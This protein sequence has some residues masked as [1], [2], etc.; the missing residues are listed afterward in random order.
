MH[1]I[2]PAYN[3]VR[4]I[5]KNKNLAKLGDAFINFAYSLAQSFLRNKPYGCKV[6]GKILADAFR[7]SALKMY[8]P[9]RSDTHTLGDFAEAIIAYVWLS[10]LLTLE[11]ITGIIKAGLS[12]FEM[13]TRRDEIE[14]A[15]Y[16]FRLLLDKISSFIIEGKI[17]AKERSTFS[18]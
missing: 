4:K 8:I 6:P 9:S 3:D 14:A 11:D 13:K 18:H 16:A 15:S 1:N 2:L 7:R 17:I 5:I 12:E 10:N